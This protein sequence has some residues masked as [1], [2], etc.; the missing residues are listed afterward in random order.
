MFVFNS[1][2]DD[3]RSI[4]LHLFLLWSKRAPIFHGAL[5]EFQLGILFFGCREK[6][7]TI[8]YTGWWF[9]RFFLILCLGTWLPT[10]IV[11]IFSQKGWNPPNPDWG[12][13]ELCFTPWVNKHLTD[14]L[15]LL[16]FDWWPLGRHQVSKF[17]RPCQEA[18]LGVQRFRLAAAGQELSVS[19]GG[20]RRRRVF[21]GVSTCRD[22]GP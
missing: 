15:T 14:M 13:K 6:Y 2:A 22:W 9:R 4:P 7:S 11:T 20:R 8:I 21:F 16:T 5:R 3:S 17:P 1:Q 12:W 18:T 10:T 19:L